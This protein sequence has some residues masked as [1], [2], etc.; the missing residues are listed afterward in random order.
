MLDKNTLRIDFKY[1]SSLDKINSGGI[2]V[3]FPQLKD[4]ISIKDKKSKNFKSLDVYK[5]GD[6]LYSGILNKN[7]KAS[8]LIVEGFD[9]NWTDTKVV[10]EF[11]L[12][13]DV[14]KLDDVLE[15]NLRGYSSNIEGEY[16]LVPTEKSSQTQDQQSYYIKI[17]DV[18]LQEEKAKIK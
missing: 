2:S 14:T 10:K 17:A 1:E 18:D 13:I 3:S 12:D 8:Y 7:V 4:E 9:E 6:D 16:E 15:I 11:S 5:A